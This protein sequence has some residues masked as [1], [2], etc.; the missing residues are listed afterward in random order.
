MCL[1]ATKIISRL[2]TGDFTRTHGWFYCLMAKISGQ[3][4]R[5]EEGT[6]SA[7]TR[8]IEFEIV[9]T[10]DVERKTVDRFSRTENLRA[11]K[12]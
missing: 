12:N 5:R 2:A 4:A 1:R 10:Q 9:C 3:G 7:Y 11:A 8:E 6:T